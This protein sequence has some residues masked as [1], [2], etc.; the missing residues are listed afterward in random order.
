M[1][2]SSQSAGRKPTPSSRL[3]T[4]ESNP[5]VAAN[6]QMEPRKRADSQG[7]DWIVM[8][9]LSKER[10][11]RYETANGFARDVERFLTNE[12]VAAGPPSASYRLRKF[13]RRNRPQ[14][15]A[16]SLVLFA[17]LAGFAGTALGL[18]R[19]RQQQRRAEAG[20]NL[21]SERL[22]QVE[23]EKK[24]TEEEKRI[25]MPVKDFA[26]QAT[27]ASRRCRAG[28][29]WRAGGPATAAKHDRTIL[30]LLNQA[31]QEVSEA[32]IE[33]NF[34][35]QPTLQTEILETVGTTYLGA[36]EP[37][38][39]IPFLQRSL[40]LCKA[41]L[42]TDHPNTLN[43]MNTLAAA[44]DHAGKLDL[45]VPLHEE[46]L[47]LTKARL[48]P[49]HP[50]TLASMNN[51]AGVYDQAGKL[52]LA[53]PLHEETLKLR[54]AKLGPDH[55]DTLMSMGNLAA[56][57]GKA[58][59]LDLAAPLHEE[60]LKLRK[61]KLGPDHPDTL[62][63]MSNLAVAYVTAGKLALAVP[64]LEETLKLQKAKRG[65]DHPDTLNTMN[66][67]SPRP[68]GKPSSSTGPSLCSRRH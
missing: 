40:A 11:R 18:M 67:A 35:N 20:E 39:A 12:P 5:G 63:S 7:L 47:K 21:A 28:E 1:K 36:G 41:T 59:N 43:V 14:V 52:D 15:I 38:R 68:F 32:K 25:A 17:L 55:P 44:Y 2:C 50:I 30:E 53:V 51:L 45:A 57:Y 24:R 64:L 42:G 54:K 19:A 16:A 29:C 65:P 22:V 8:K 61:A 6:R 58:G 37:G 46:T 31:A 60:T 10:D 49:D 62:T 26:K 66:P 13:V 33:A 4:M 23:A 27:R 9:A 48:G 34:P 56:T 3:S